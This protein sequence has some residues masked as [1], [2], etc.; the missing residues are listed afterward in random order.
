MNSN[1]QDKEH[2]QSFLAERNDELD[3]AAFCLLALL[4]Q[5]CGHGDL[6]EGGEFPWDMAKIGPLLDAAKSILDDDSFAYCHP[7]YEDEVPCYQTTS[8]NYCDC[9]FHQ[10][11]AEQKTN[12]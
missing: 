2:F 3:H 4:C 1:M 10:P 6:L 9:I 12:Q 7:F 11:Q 8:C 5:Q